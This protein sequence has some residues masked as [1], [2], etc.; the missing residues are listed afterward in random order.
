[1]KKSDV[2]GPIPNNLRKYRKLSGYRQLDVAERLRI[3]PG[4][5]RKWEKGTQFPGIEN[6]FKLCHFYN[7]SEYQL[8][9]EYIDRLEAEIKK[10]LAK[11]KI[12]P[13]RITN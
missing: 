6:F 12:K 4:T 2:Q 9:G 10:R 3:D 11:L 1:M 5:V 13:R 8:Y 7:A